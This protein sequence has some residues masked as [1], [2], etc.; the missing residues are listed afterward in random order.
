[1]IACASS[2]LIQGYARQPGGS[3]D[4]RPQGLSSAHLIVEYGVYEWL[5]FQSG[6]PVDSAGPARRAGRVRVAAVPADRRH[7]HA[8]AAALAERLSRPVDQDRLGSGDHDLLDA[9]G[10]SFDAFLG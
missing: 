8:L 6:L 9:G 2:Y 5:V 10:G 7:P 4:H 1:M 3:G